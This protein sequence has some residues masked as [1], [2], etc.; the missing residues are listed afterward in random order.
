M[1]SSF[2]NGNGAWNAP[3]DISLLI[4][5]WNDFVRKIVT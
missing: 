1:V 4:G 3:Y 2:T 5:N